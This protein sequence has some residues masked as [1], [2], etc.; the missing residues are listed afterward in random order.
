MTRTPNSSITNALH[1][2]KC[3]SIDHPEL[4]LSD[5]ANYTDISKSTACRLLQTLESEGFIHQNANDN[6]YRLGSALLSLTHTAINQFTF[7][8]EMTP[9][10]KNLTNYTKETSYIALLEHKDVIYI[11][12]ED[13]PFRVQMLSHIGRRNPAYCTGSGLAMLAFIDEQ[14]I[15]DMFPQQLPTYTKHTISTLEEL[16][17][18]LK[19]IRKQGYAISK[20]QYTENI[21]SIGA[22][23]FN[24]K[25]KVIASITV[26][27]P[28]NRIMI[29]LHK[30]IEALIQESDKIT[31][32]IERKEEDV[33]LEIFTK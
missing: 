25:Q 5:I 30:F 3:F 4:S 19:V 16:Q 12:K 28:I 6:T 18:E 14:T 1:I 17:E 13:S 29:N 2:L 31:N 10:L 33:L 20:G 15:S 9:F 8:K 23:I 24:T 32:F 27:G 22:P 7:L 11:K 21:I 26:T